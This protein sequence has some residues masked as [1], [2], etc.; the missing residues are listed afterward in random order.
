[1]KIETRFNAG[2]RVVVIEE[3]KDFINEKI[4]PYKVK[5]F[6]DFQMF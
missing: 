4:K 6:N 2:D 1:M 5:D 3:G